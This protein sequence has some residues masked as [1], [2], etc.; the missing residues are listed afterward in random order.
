MNSIRRL[1]AL[2]LVCVLLLC[3]TACTLQQAPSDVTDTSGNQTEVAPPNISY[4]SHTCPEEDPYVG[5]DKEAFYA[6]YEPACCNQDAINR[7][8][9]GLLSGL[10]HVPGQYVQEAEAR[11]QADG[12]FIRNTASVYLDNGNTYVIFDASGRETLRIH[13]AGGYITLEEV[14]AYMYAF[15]GSE[16]RFPAN[17]TSKKLTNIGTSIWGEYV[18]GNHSHFIGNTDRYPYEPELPNIS[19][20]GGSLQYFEMDIGTTGT[21]TEGYH[22]RP[23][24]QNGKITRGAARLVYAR[25]DLN[26]NGTYEINEIYVF[27]THNHYNDFRE[28]LNYYGGWGEVFGNETG[29]GKLSSKTEANPTP[30]IPTAYDDFTSQ[31][32]KAL[33]RRIFRNE[34]DDFRAI[35]ECA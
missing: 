21:V 26:G 19:G 12:K 18:R 16:G 28:Y 4:D 33:C 17:Y 10:L 9:H 31:A 11:P 23:Y 22:A 29:G 7:S 8:K 32:N 24:V 13:K 34:T 30:Y 20:C 1:I 3:F 15:G 14:A 27:Y 25:E 5:V 6:E 35:I 2:L